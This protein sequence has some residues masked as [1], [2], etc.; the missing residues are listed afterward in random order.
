M[1]D[2]HLDIT[3]PESLKAAQEYLATVFEGKGSYEVHLMGE[4]DKR[5]TNLQNRALHKWCEMCS[6]VLNEA[7]LNQYVFFEILNKHGLE[8]DWNKSTFKEEVFKRTQ[9]AM[10]QKESTKEANTKDYS[11][12]YN[13]LCRFFASH[14]VVLPPWPDRFN[15]E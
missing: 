15:Q 4:V 13:S 2:Y 10:T 3:S 12:V 7:G 5:R 1:I 8:L 9:K 6:E 14:D 11:G